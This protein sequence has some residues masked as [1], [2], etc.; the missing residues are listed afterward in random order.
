[1]KHP[2]FASSRLLVPALRKLIYVKISFHHPDISQA[3][4]SDGDCVYVEEESFGFIEFARYRGM[5]G[6]MHLGYPKHAR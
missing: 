5:F 2:H 6:H 4:T 1:M 3:E